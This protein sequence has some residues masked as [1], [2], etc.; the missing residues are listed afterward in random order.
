MVALARLGDGD[1]RATI[2]NMFRNTA[3]PYL[4]IHGAASLELFGSPQSLPVPPDRAAEGTDS[5]GPWTK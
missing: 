4:L 2:E 3:N 1:S 5:T